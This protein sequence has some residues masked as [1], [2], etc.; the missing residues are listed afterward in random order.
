MRFR[1]MHEFRM[2]QNDN[3]GDFNSHGFDE[4]KDNVTRTYDME[5]DSDVDPVTDLGSR[6]IYDEGDKTQPN[7]TAWRKILRTAVRFGPNRISRAIFSFAVSNIRNG[8][9]DPD[10]TIPGGSSWNIILEN[11][12][13]VANNSSVAIEFDLDL[14]SDEGTLIDSVAN[15]ERD[16]RDGVALVDNSEGSVDFTD[17]R[18]IRW[19]RKVFCDGTKEVTVRV[20]LVRILTENPDSGFT[21]RKRI[22]V[23]FHISRAERC[24]RLTWDPTTDLA[25]EDDVISGTDTS[26]S[27]GGSTNTNTGGSTTNTGGSTTANTGSTTTNTGS[28]TTNTGVSTGGSSTSSANKLL[29]AMLL[30]IV[31]VVAL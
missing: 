30:A 19:K 24:Y 14:D 4:T 26:S 25:P 20:R 5:T 28:S 17:K 16:D 8:I 27:T 2:R 22:I 9:D 13:Y 7:T 15:V 11:I 10:V 12:P 3:D 21:I 18:R 31:A 1:R 6:P 29:F 23:T